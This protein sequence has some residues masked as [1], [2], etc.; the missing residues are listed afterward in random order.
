MLRHT[1]CSHLAMRGVPVTAIQK[2]AGNQHL[3]TTHVVAGAQCSIA[4][5]GL[6]LILAPPVHAQPAEKIRVHVALESVDGFVSGD[7]LLTKAANEVEAQVARHKRVVPMRTPTD[8]DVVLWI[9]KLSEETTSGGALEGRCADL[10]R[11]SWK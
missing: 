6:T 1:F 11:R 2:M 3:S 9:S 5:F 8:A 4:V 7:P 10:L